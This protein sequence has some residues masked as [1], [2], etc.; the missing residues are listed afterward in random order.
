MKQGVWAAI[1]VALITGIVASL[2]FLS[3]KAILGVSIFALIDAAMF[4]LIAY[5]IHKKSRTAAVSGL[6]VYLLERLYMLKSGGANGGG[7]T[8]MAMFLTLAFVTAIRGTFAYAR[9]QY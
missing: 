3:H 2:S 4:A 6:C 1:F 8:L 9:R 5:G 7:A